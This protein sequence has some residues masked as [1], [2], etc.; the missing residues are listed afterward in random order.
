MNL[1]RAA[2][3]ARA[4]VRKSV[5]RR[6]GSPETRAVPVKPAI[7]ATPAEAA[8]AAHPPNRAMS[9]AE[10]RTIFFGLML[11]AFLA[12]LNQTIIATALPTIGRVFGD[13]ENLPWIVTAYLLTSTAVAPLY[14]KLSDIWGRRAMILVAI[15]LFIAGSTA[16][17]AAPSMTMLILGRALQGIGGG[18][19]LPLCQSVI[20]DVV[21]PRERGRYQAYMGV[22]WVTSGVCG[23]VFGG[24]MAEH[25]H[26]SLIFWINVPLGLGAA[27]LT[28]IY[29]KRIPR[30]DRRHKL[31][32]LGAVLMMASAVPLLLA[33]TWGGTRLPWL[34]APIVALIAASFVLSLL[35]GWRLT[36]AEEPF[37]PLTV[38]NNPVMRMGTASASLAM[39]V[40]IGLTIVVPMYF[41]I[42]HH[43]SATESGL[44]LIPLAL[45]TPGSLLSGQ[46]MLYWKHYK[47]APMFGLVCALVALVVLIWR[48][49]LSLTY[50]IVLLSVVGTAIGLVYPVTTVSIQNAVPHHQVGIAMGALNFF[51]SL[52]SAFVVA[53][54]GAILLAGLGVAPE[55]GGHAVSVMGTM[56]A[57]GDGHVAFVFRWVFLASWVFLAASLAFLVLMEERPLRATAAPEEP[58]RA[59]PPV[60]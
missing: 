34:S 55:R 46:A 47:R 50:V 30:H 11:A 25:L 13:L 58:P 29:L 7:A 49:D 6:H 51:R 28:H 31:D 12:A 1:S 52:T 26:W 24:M 56:S 17:A 8:A 23:P 57:A 4:R 2:A 41:E 32:V 5:R 59:S 27:A 21:A 20:A 35:F 15:G 48:P 40:S 43:L 44:A 16:A 54:L 60:R 38:L 14:G 53:V 36:R 19:I 9:H 3:R 18:G 22:V 33:L 45:T 39:G 37:L 42:A 10:V